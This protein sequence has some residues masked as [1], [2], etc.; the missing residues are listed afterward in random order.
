M[1]VAA[2]RILFRAFHEASF[3]WVAMDVP[4]YFRSSRFAANVC[5]EVAGL[6]EL[7][8]GALESP[9][10]HLLEGL[11]KL[12]KQYIWGLVEKQMD[13]LE[14]ENVGVNAG[15]V[16]RAGLFENFLDSGLGI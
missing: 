9:R 7:L 5:V 12:T 10:C 16:T 2:P 6:P 13:V 8:D 4:D 3:D 11:E 1:V 14:H 15:A